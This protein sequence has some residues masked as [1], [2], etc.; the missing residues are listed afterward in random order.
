[1]LKKKFKRTTADDWFSKFIRLRDII[2]GE[3]CR[4]ITCGKP[5][6]WKYEAQ[7][8]HYATRG[9]P[10]T[11]F[12]EQNCHAQCPTCNSPDHGKGEQAKHGFAIDR[13][14]GD[15]TAK[16]LIALS[17]IRGQKVYIKLRLKDIA[18]EYRLKAKTMAKEKGVEL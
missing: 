13:L 8:G 7:C 2:S 10:M 16:K 3:Y 18:K 4:C 14:Y 1:M 17:E 11:R 15:G 6:H 12:M 9:K 5:I